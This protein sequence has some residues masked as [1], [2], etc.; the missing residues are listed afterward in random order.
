MLLSARPVEPADFPGL[1]LPLESFW[2]VA[3]DRRLVSWLRAKTG[4]PA[5]IVSDE[6]DLAA[7]S[8]LEFA[9]EAGTIVLRVEPPP[10]PAFELISSLAKSQPSM[11]REAMQAAYADPIARLAGALPGLRLMHVRPGMPTSHQPA[12]GLACTAWRL[13]VMAPG[14]SVLGWLSRQLQH[15]ALAEL[16]PWL[17]LRLP[18]RCVLFERTL[19]PKEVLS[20]RVGDIV[21][22]PGTTGTRLPV[23]ICFGEGPTLEAHAHLEERAAEQ[24]GMLGGESVVLDSEVK[25]V[26]KGDLGRLAELGLP[27]SFEIDSGRMPL[28]ELAALGPGAVLGLAS[29]LREATVRLTCH[30][31]VLGHGRL[32][33]I[34]ERLGVRIEHMGLSR[35]L[36][37]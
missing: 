33:A 28:A 6:P 24:E 25:P 13:Q 14:P 37:A 18:L 11:A 2:R 15:A 30:G 19:G 10:Y 3:A 34:G 5:L 31:Q 7:G 9:F 27:V 8:D 16:D 22:H 21:L 35:E 26:T 36:L 23:R 4:E 32:V 29:P 1:A 17:A 20:L 12:V